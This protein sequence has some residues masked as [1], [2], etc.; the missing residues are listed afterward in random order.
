MYQ[1]TCQL[2]GGIIDLTDGTAI[3]IDIRR[4]FDDPEIAELA[5]TLTYRFCGQLHM[6][7]WLGST[8]LP[9]YKPDSDDSEGLVDTIVGLFFFGI[10]LAILVGAGYGFLLLV[11][12]IF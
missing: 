1:N 12:E 2:C 8:T 9:A 10:F 7:Q 4:G 6:T 3:E 11:R 5:Q